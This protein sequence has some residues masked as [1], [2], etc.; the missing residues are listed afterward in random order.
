MYKGEKWT[1]G[2]GQSADITATHNC[3]GCCK[4]PTFPAP[5]AAF[6]QGSTGFPVGMR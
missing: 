3:N 5:L 2:G 6:G 1:G 4:E